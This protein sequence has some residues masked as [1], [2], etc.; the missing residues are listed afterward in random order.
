MR[1][2]IEPTSSWTLWQFLNPLSHKRN[3]RKF[4][5]YK[6]CEAYILFLGRDPCCLAELLGSP[7]TH[8]ISHYELLCQSWS[9]ADGKPLVATADGAGQVHVSLV[10]MMRHVLPLTSGITWQLPSQAHWVQ[11]QAGF[12]P[13]LRKVPGFLKGLYIGPLTCLQC[14]ATS[15]QCFQ[16]CREESLHGADF[17]Q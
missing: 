9:W 7:G 3:S 13:S 1:P 11:L 12:F 2:G 5:F 17:W 6:N 16:G 8:Q 4:I 10:G 14:L 15:L